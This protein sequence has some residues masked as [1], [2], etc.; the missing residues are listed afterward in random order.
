MVF[1]YK[2]LLLA[3]TRKDVNVG[4]SIKYVFYSSQHQGRPN[5]QK[6]TKKQT[7]QT[8]TPLHFHFHKIR[9]FLLLPVELGEICGKNMKREVHYTFTL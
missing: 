1:C 9:M 5:Q 3:W 2:G 8:D 7:N 6:E 4:E